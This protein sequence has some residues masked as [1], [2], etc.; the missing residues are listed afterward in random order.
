MASPDPAAE[1]QRIL[2]VDEIVANAKARAESLSEE[3]RRAD[4][5]EAARHRQS[6]DRYVAQVAARVEWI[7]RRARISRRR[8]SRTRRHGEVLPVRLHQPKHR[9]RGAG[10]PKLR[11]V[12]RRITRSSSRSGDSGSEP[13]SSR[14]LVDRRDAERQT[15]LD[16][17]WDAGFAAGWWRGYADAEAA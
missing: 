12:A 16:A 10:R 9:P 8:S 6:V 1:P 2:T 11:R 7:E 13:P 3:E 15:A 14:R 17:A 5:E 4:A